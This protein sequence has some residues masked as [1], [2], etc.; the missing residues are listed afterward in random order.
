MAFV[1]WVCF[2]GLVLALLA[3]D[4]GV[5]N[6]G[7]HVIS[8]R[9]AL[10]W[11]AFWI[12]LSGL[13]AIFIYFAYEN[14]WLGIGHTVGHDLGG[15]RAAFEY[16]AGYLVEKSLSLDNIF[17]IALIF[18]YF[19]VPREY[20]HRTLFWGI[21][22]ALVMRG[23]MIAAGSE[24]INR[25]SWTNYLFGGLLIFTAVR[26]MVTEADKIDPEKSLLVR[27]ARHIYRVS[28][29][30]D[31][32][33]FF[34]RIHGKRAMTLLFVVLLAIEGADVLFAVDS[35]PA[36]F[37][38][39][40]DPFLVF[41]SNIFAI[42]GLRSLFFALAAAMHKFRYIKQSLVFLLATIGVKML[43]AHHFEIPTWVSLLVIVVILSVGVLASLW[44]N[45]RGGG[46]GA[47]EPPSAGGTSVDDGWNIDA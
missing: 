37:A 26:M 1:P 43:L 2:I 10:W 27:L 13:F 4:L 11:T 12:G 8:A 5:L 16:A 24:L 40:K 25:F 30:L 44:D 45:W 15:Q 20:Q 28:D 14:Y 35:I 21:I 22:G 9:A 19:R 47:S 29:R 31:G 46:G 34:T 39:T 17:V 33:K 36:I 38:I 42:L 3:L 7:S 6:R 32:K 18:T 41:T 23:A